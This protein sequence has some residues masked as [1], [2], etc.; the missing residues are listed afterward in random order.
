MESFTGFI[1]PNKNIVA[2]RLAQTRFF[3]QKSFTTI[4]KEQ[5]LFRK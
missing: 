4:G 1:P 2:G 5:W 3:S